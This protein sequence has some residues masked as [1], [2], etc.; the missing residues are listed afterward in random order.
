M[1][2]PMD[3]VVSEEISEFLNASKCYNPSETSPEIIVYC[4]NHLIN[5]TT[6]LLSEERDHNKFVEV[7]YNIDANLQPVLKIGCLGCSDFAECGVTCKADDVNCVK[8]IQFSEDEWVN[9]LIN[10]EQVFLQKDAKRE[11]L[12][13]EDRKI[14]DLVSGTLYHCGLYRSEFSELFRLK[15]VINYRLE[16]LNSYDLPAFYERFI[17]LVAELTE[18]ETDERIIND[19]YTLLNYE[20]NIN[21]HNILCVLEIITVYPHKV[22]KAVKRVRGW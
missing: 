9:K 3:Q 6:Y 5:N 10:R 15:D 19:A 1:T 14:I 11:L 18:E 22:I 21:Y 17:K 2:T 4:E 16:L 7:G 13:E 12:K 20:L 8:T